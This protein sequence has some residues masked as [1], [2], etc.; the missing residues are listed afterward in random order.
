MLRM[1]SAPK[2]SKAEKAVL[3]KLLPFFNAAAQN[4]KEAIKTEGAKK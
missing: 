4:A 2:G 3:N 1:A